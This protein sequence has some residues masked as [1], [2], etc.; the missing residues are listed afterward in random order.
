MSPDL[1]WQISSDTEE[2][3]I[4]QQARPP[5]WH[6]WGVLAAVALGVGLGLAYASIPE[7][8]SAPTPTLPPPTIPARPALAANSLEA[9]V[10]RDAFALGAS[11]GE[12]NFDLGLSGI[13]TLDDEQYAE[14]Y[15]TLLSAGG[16]WGVYPADQLYSI[17][18]LGTAGGL[19]WVDVEQRRGAG[20][21]RQT[22][23]YRRTPDGWHLALPARGLWSGGMIAIDTGQL[24]SSGPGKLLFDLAYPVEDADYV[25]LIVERFS[26]AFARLCGDLEC[27]LQP[28]WDL[29]WGRPVA[30]TVAVRSAPWHTYELNGDVRPVSVR[31]PSP[32]VIGVYT[33]PQRGDPLMSIAL[34][35]LLEPVARLASGDA[36]R[37]ATDKGGHL[38]LD[39]ILNWQRLRVAL[40]DGPLSLFFREPRGG[41]IRPPS[42]LSSI[43]APAY[44]ANRLAGQPRRP[45]AALWNWSGNEGP[46]AS[47]A[48]TA[49]VDQADAVIAFIVSTR[50]EG[51]VVD[52]LQALGQA[53]SL[54]EA[55]EEGLNADYDDF[56]ADWQQWLNP[57]SS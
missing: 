12:A 19:S 26:A 42:P 15:Y 56:E 23:F 54:R 46:S 49:A 29:R 57:P 5:R 35:A 51:A 37:W 41:L 28:P 18:G 2:R 48:D 30:L 52:F 6:R 27:G 1:D 33:P 43:S 22:R 31:L 8:P 21:F 50:G 11:A 25:P 4:R 14:W 9:A 40:S 24:E 55:V 10:E 47:T 39:A 20:S 53:R 38:F 45:L 7:P 36:G 32:R 16:R 34:D 13:D 3:R 44:F 17:R